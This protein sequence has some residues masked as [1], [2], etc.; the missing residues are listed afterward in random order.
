MAKRR[1]HKHKSHRQMQAQKFE[2]QYREHLKFLKSVRAAPIS[3]A[4]FR[5]NLQGKSYKLRKQKPLTEQSLP[6]NYRVDEVPS[7][8]ITDSRADSCARNNVM[9]LTNLSRESEETRREIVAKS[10]RLAPAYNKGAYQYIDGETF[11][12]KK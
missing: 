10:K 11:A 5:A 12:R 6:A 1:K 4:E 9:E 3:R 8:G 7:K 2:Q